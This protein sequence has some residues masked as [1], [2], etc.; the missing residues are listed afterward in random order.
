MN[1][2]PAK[3][4]NDSEFCHQLLAIVDGTE[5]PGFNVY[6]QLNDVSVGNVPLDRAEPY[7]DAKVY[8][9]ISKKHLEGSTVK[10]LRIETWHDKSDYYDR[11]GN[12]LCPKC[13]TI[14][15]VFGREERGHVLVVTFECP[16]HGMFTKDISVK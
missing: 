5:I 10:I 3:Q 11:D 6:N 2:L 16:N 14:S 13:D 7:F 4:T 1:Y 9:A 8:R 15:T 12:T